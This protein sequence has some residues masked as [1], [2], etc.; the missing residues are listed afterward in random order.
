MSRLTVSFL[1][2]GCRVNQYEIR[3]FMERLQ[4]EVEIVPFGQCADVTIIDSCVVTRTAERDTRQMVHRA[5][6]ASP[7]GTVLLTGCYVDIHPEA[8]RQIEPGVFVFGREEKSSIP[9]WIETHFGLQAPPEPIFAEPEGE[10]PWP[11]A[12]RPPLVVQTGCDRR[13]AYCII[14]LARGPSKSRP[15][16]EAVRELERF[17]REPVSEVVLSGINLGAWGADLRPRAKLADLLRALLDATPPGRRLRLGSIEPETIDGDLLSLLDHPRLAPHFHVPLQGTTSEVLRAMRRPL[18]AAE[19]AGLVERLRARVPG[20]ALGADVIVGFPGETGAL[21]EEGLAFVEKCGF[22]YLHVFPFSP[23]PGTPAASM[24]QLPPAVIREHAARMR[25]LAERLRESFLQAQEGRTAQV[26]IEK[27][28][29]DAVAEGMADRFFPVRFPVPP[30]FLR[31]ELV[32]VRLVKRE[33]DGYRGKL[34]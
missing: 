26:A 3:Q 16:E 18:D 7:E 13:C 32:Q 10:S 1:S 30:G 21:F 4:G 22:S 20:C 31:R 17:F 9:A 2:L 11:S 6:R 12:G 15:M 27:I 8:S 25:Q 34:P 33:P 19:Y 28:T 24:P 5:R 14:P 29:Q 23:R